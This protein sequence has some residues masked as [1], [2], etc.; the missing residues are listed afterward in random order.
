LWFDIYA[1]GGLIPFILFAYFSFI[2]IRD[3]VITNRVGLSKSNHMIASGMILGFFS[4]SLFEPT[5]IVNSYTFGA[6]F[7]LI[8]L[9]SFDKVPGRLER[10]SNRISMKVRTNFIEIKI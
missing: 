7:S 10:L 1:D 9:T 6:F 2:L 3:I 8:M 5:L 4:I